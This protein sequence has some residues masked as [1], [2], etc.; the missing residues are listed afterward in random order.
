M[1]QTDNPSR[2]K[3]EHKSNSYNSNHKDYNTLFHK[4]IRQYG[5][6]NFNFEILEEKIVSSQEEADELESFWIKQK[7]SYVKNNEGYNLTTGGQKTKSCF[8]KAKINKDILMQIIDKIKNTNLS[9]AKIEKIFNLS[10][11]YVSDI[12]TGYHFHLS[13]ETY[14]IRPLREINKQEILEFMLNHTD[15]TQKQIAENFQ[16]SVS[17]IKRIKS[18]NRALFQ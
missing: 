12:N 7:N 15:L 5:Y 1:G 17:T 3:S 13:T 14:P 16:V 9:F 11:G 10:K 2:R 8:N 4:K 18:T 6:D